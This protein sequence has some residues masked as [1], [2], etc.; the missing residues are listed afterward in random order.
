MAQIVSQ[1][2]ISKKILEL[3]R[4]WTQSQES[5][6]PGTGETIIIDDLADQRT[7]FS[8]ES[9]VRLENG[10]QQILE[11]SGCLPYDH[12]LKI[13]NSIAYQE[14]IG[15]EATVEAV[16]K[17]GGDFV[18]VPEDYLVALRKSVEDLQSSIGNSPS[19]P[20]GDRPDL[21][22]W[23][24]AII[25]D[26]FDFLKSRCPIL[27]P[28]DIS[29]IESDGHPEFAARVK[30]DEFGRLICVMPSL[31]T[32]TPLF[33]YQMI[34]EVLGHGLHFSQL[35]ANKLLQKGTPHLL[36]LSIHTHEN[37]FLEAMAQLITTKML[38]S[39]WN[40]PNKKK[41]QLCDLKERLVRAS[42]HKILPKLL[43]A[44]ISIDEA[45]RLHMNY[46]P[47]MLN[48]EII[49]RRYSALKASTFNS[50]VF[51]NYFSAFKAVEPLLAAKEEQFFSIFPP[52]IQEYYTPESL[53]Q[54][55]KSVCEPKF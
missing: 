46:C 48:G 39:D 6:A 47:G 29:L 54:F 13:H 23:V 33:L 14:S 16:A 19:P 11:S 53:R 2:E 3:Y 52:L 9:P 1:S 7:L 43:A 34:H 17:T 32:P 31:Q 51:A 42:I 4:Q 50:K 44:E 35:K 25:D 30:T 5:M 28:I 24:Q 20:A 37:F 26:G 45:A 10:F 22:I 21:M 40:L 55:V 12:V 36:A 18:E 41:I 15:K 8:E 27:Q 38:W 49:K